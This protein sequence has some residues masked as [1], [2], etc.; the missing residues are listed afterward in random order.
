MRKELDFVAD[1]GR[2][3]GKTFRITEMSA[4]RAEKWCLRAFFALLN[5]GADIPD[6][7]ASQGFSGLMA[8]GPAFLEAFAR[9]PYESV[10]PLWDDLMTCVRYVPVANQP[11]LTRPL[12]DEDIDEVQTLMKLKK[13]VFDLHTEFLKTGSPSA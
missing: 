11:N 12:V 13:L 9:V 1:F 7:L 6:G 4:M 5:A 3:E 8:M 2:D 10:V